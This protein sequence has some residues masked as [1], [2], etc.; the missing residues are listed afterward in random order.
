MAPRNLG[1]RNMKQNQPRLNI[2]KVKLNNGPNSIL[3]QTSYPKLNLKKKETG[4]KIAWS[5][6]IQKKNKTM[7]PF[8]FL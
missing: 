3:I 7:T 5:K 1:N 4:S 6:S 8:L 2:L